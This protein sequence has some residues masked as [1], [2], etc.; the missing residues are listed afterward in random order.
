MAGYCGVFQFHRTCGICAV[1]QGQRAHDKPDCAITIRCLPRQFHAGASDLRQPWRFCPAPATRRAY[2]PH[3]GEVG[4]R[5]RT[6]GSPH[7]SP[8]APRKRPLLRHGLGDIGGI[9]QPEDSRQP[10]RYGMTQGQRGSLTSW[11][12]T[13]KSDA[14]RDSCTPV[15]QIPEAPEDPG[16]IRKRLRI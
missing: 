11:I 5:P 15:H 10:R 1:Y 3:G 9:R 8:V 12:C 2:G 7:G 14:C 13:D 4:H 6:T 16:Q